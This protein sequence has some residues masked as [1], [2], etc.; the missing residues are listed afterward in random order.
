MSDIVK[1]EAVDGVGIVTTY[2]DFKSFPKIARIS[3]DCVITEKID[4]SNAQVT[5]KDGAVLSIG[6][7]NRFITEQADNFGFARWVG[8]NKDELVKLGDGT[9]FG[10]WWGIGIQRGYGLFER[11]FTLF[12]VPKD[13]VELPKC[14]SVVPTL[15]TGPFAT[16]IVDRVLAYLVVKGS[17]AVPGYMK[18]EGIVIYHKAAGVMFKKTTENDEVPKGEANVKS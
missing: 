16:E 6:S 5:I 8:Q 15:Y 4:G 3:R 13:L 7:R 2:Q 14:V 1:E 9:H 10:E 12:R 11:R 18:P 17:V